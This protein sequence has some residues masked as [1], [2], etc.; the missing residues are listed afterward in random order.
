M[1]HYLSPRRSKT[2]AKAP[3]LT[4]THRAGVIGLTCALELAKAGHQVTVLAQDLPGDSSINYASPRAGAHFRPITATT[5]QEIFEA[6]LMRESY[7]ELEALARSDKTAG[8]QM[9]PA[10]EYFSAA[11]T[12]DTRAQFATW[13][14]FRVLDGAEL[15]SGNC[16]RSGLTYAAWV[17]NSPVYLAWLRAQAESRGA[18]FVRE[19]LSAIPEAFFLARQHRGG[20][21]P[22]PGVVVNASGM[23]FGDAACFPS[24]GQFLLLSNQYDRTVSH[25]CLDGQSTVVIPR[26]LGGGTVVGGTKEPNNW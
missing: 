17:L 5:E 14:G 6:A 18:V 8:V 2:T 4:S 9:V 25:H 3:L 21:L 1:L 13:P 20:G 19:S 15:P 22:A 23:G 7:A 16:I 12:G 11:L 10:V 24:R 26:P